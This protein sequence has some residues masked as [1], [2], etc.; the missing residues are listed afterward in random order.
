M[1]YYEFWSSDILTGNQTYSLIL[2]TVKRFWSSDILTGNQTQE[3]INMIIA[4]DLPNVNI[5]CEI[6]YN[7]RI[8]DYGRTIYEEVFPG[9]NRVLRIEIGPQKLPTDEELRDTIIHE[10]LEA[11]IIAR[12][13]LL[14]TSPS[15]RD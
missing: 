11:K 15:P 9:Y 4:R 3:D 12:D 7:P 10:I 1:D 2:P 8:K 14:Y 13:C 6:V 5:P